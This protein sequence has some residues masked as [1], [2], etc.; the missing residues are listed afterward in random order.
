MSTRASRSDAPPSVLTK[1]ELDE[2][3]EIVARS[4]R[5]SWDEL[6]AGAETYSLTYTSYETGD[7]AEI[8]NVEVPLLPV[9]LTPEEA[10]AHYFELEEIIQ[11]E[12]YDVAHRVAETQQLQLRGPIGAYFEVCFGRALSNVRGRQLNRLRKL[13]YDADDAIDRYFAARQRLYEEGEQGT[14]YETEGA[15]AYAELEALH[16]SAIALSMCVEILG[17]NVRNPRRTRDDG[18]D[19]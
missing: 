8:L 1:E 7:D 6:L 17:R 3:W 4:R 12:I 19:F 16:D 9:P 5:P 2:A 13:V 14:S 15:L 11:L 18:G 10:L